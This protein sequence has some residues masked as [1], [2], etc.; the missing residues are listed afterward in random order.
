[1]VYRNGKINDI[2]NLEKFWSQMHEKNRNE[3]GRKAI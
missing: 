2:A 1:M 3:M